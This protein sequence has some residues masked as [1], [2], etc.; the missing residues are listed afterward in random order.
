[1]Y[2]VP[3]FIIL[4]YL[5]LSFTD[6]EY[7]LAVSFQLKHKLRRNQMHLDAVRALTDAM[8]KPLYL[9]GESC[10]YSFSLRFREML[11]L[12]RCTMG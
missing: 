11:H 7:L 6:T 4:A 1:M 3:I 12:E 5:Y 8:V 2:F 9:Y 10:A